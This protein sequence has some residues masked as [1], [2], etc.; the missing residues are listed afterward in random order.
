MIA[1]RHTL[2]NALRIAADQYDADALVHNTPPADA[3][4][5]SDDGRKRLVRCFQDQATDAR[6]LADAIEQA[7]TIMLE[8]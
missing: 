8:D 4:Y 7:G 1:K 3:M 6:K 2:A 5:W